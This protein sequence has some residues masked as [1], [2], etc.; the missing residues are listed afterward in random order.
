MTYMSLVQSILNTFITA[1]QH[2]LEVLSS[3]GASGKLAQTSL[4]PS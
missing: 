4:I 2:V 3:P 1:D